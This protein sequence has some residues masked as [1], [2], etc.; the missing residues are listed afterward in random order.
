MSCIVGVAA[1]VRSLVRVAQS[2]RRMLVLDG[3]PLACCR[4]AL[5]ARKIDPD[6][7]IVLSSVGLK[8]HMHADLDDAEI[9][10]LWQDTILPALKDLDEGLP[11]LHLHAVPSQA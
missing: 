8:K 7:Y 1:G 6:V 9:E 4:H 5:E 11:K 10:K 2:G 3:C